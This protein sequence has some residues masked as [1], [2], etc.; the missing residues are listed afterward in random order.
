MEPFADRG[1]TYRQMGRYEEAFADLNTAIN[2]DPESAWAIGTRGQVYQ[3]MDRHEE[4]VADLTRAIELDP[5]LAW[6]LAER[7]ET[8]RLMGRHTPDGR[9]TGT[10]GLKTLARIWHREP[11]GAVYDRC[12]PDTYLTRGLPI[13]AGISLGSN[14]IRPGQSG[15]E[16]VNPGVGYHA[17]SLPPV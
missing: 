2:L 12:Q 4:A 8:Y 13:R 17:A 15:N 16:H 5:E 10:S 11:P 3:A 1:E 7:D 14:S 6:A 9:L